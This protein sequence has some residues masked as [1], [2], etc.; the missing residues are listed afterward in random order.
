MRDLG[1]WLRTGPLADA[2][3]QA[4]LPTD[5]LTTLITTATQQ[6]A[7]TDVELRPGAQGVFPQDARAAVAEAAQRVLAPDA[8]GAAWLAADALRHAC[9]AELASLGTTLSEDKAEL[10]SL[11]SLRPWISAAEPQAPTAPQPPSPPAPPLPDSPVHAAQADAGS[12]IENAPGTASASSQGTQDHAAVGTAQAAYDAEV[13]AYE[14]ACAYY[15]AARAQYAADRAQYE[16]DLQLWQR[17]TA[18]GALQLGRQITALEYRIE[19]KRLLGACTD[20]LV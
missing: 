20:K 14:V 19:K 13:A 5:T 1:Q 6:G 16:R 11:R 9:A 18:M 12:H 2:A 4:Q 3:A 10:D 15:E 7:L 17:V 8:A